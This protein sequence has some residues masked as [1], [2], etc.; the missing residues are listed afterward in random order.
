MVEYDIFVPLSMPD[1]EAVA[2]RQIVALKQRLVR[3]FGGLTY[4]PQRNEGIWKFG[5]YIFRDKIVILRV[6]GETGPATTRF[7]RKLKSEIERD[8]HQKEVLIISRQIKV[9]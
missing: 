2:K 5:N 7:L 3:Q 6:L 4:F 8:W 1:G 9:F